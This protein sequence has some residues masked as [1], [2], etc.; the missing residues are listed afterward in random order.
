MITLFIIGATLLFAGFYFLAD[1]G[2]KFF[3]NITIVGAFL[4]I[5]AL[6][7]LLLYPGGISYEIDQY[8]QEKTTYKMVRQSEEYKNMSDLEKTNFLSYLVSLHDSMLTYK[9]NNKSWLLDW[10]IPDKIERVE[11][12]EFQKGE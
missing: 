2:S 6:L 3:A 11:L 9:K 7:F 12:L 4:S 10:Y 8:E 5:L 1:D